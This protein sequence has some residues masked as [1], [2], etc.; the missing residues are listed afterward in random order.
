VPKKNLIPNQIFKLKF[1]LNRKIF[2]ALVI[3]AVSS[4]S[5]SSLGVFR[6]SSYKSFL[7]HELREKRIYSDGRTLLY[8]KVLPVTEKLIEEQKK[9]FFE[10]SVKIHNDR[11][12]LLVAISL[13]GREEFL[14][15]D[16]KYRWNQKSADDVKEIYDQN[17][18]ENHYPF[19]FPFHRLFIVSFLV[20]EFFLQNLGKSQFDI[21]SVVGRVTVELNQPSILSSS[22]NL[23]L[24]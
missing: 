9:V 23:R 10:S 19:A 6:D 12:E 4:C 11:I 18:L 16:L 8:A 24:E 5:H 2:F 1:N 22:Q 13:V 14:I 21:E 17:V 15:H 7:R 3:C 20:D